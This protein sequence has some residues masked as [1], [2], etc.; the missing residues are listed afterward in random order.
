M[1]AIAK[2]SL[3][4]VSLV[5]LIVSGYAGYYWYTY[6]DETITEGQ[7][8]GFVIGESK[9]EAY[10]KAPG[11]LI[12]LEGE[13]TS[14]YIEV[15]VDA[16]SAELLATRA[17][18][19]LMVPAKLDDVGY[20]LFELQDLWEFFIDGSYYNNLKLKF[21]DEMLCE[22]HRHRKNFEIP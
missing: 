12:R 4:A 20:P 14:V 3:F 18:Y 22:I 16:D 21:C 6:I 10:K 19:P 13:N 7:G 5:V 15:K 8:Y 17:D 9:A 11:A 1:R 2:F